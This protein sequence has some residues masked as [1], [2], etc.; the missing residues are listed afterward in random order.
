LLIYNAS[1]IF[2]ILFWINSERF[3]RLALP[4]HPRSTGLSP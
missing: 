4:T 2:I 3:T 1:L